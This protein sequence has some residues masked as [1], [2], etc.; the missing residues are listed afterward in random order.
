LIRAALC[1]TPEIAELAR[2]H[3]NANVLC[4]G[5][6]VTDH[7]LCE[8]ILETFLSTPFEGGR[9]AGRVKKLSC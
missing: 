1:W 5:A 8:K 2:A 6:R 4:L 9:H 7:T 3:N